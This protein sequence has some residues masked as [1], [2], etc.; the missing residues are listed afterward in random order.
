MRVLVAGCGYVGTE[1]GL[2]LAADGHE[3]WGLRRTPADLPSPIRPLA[4]D[5]TIPATLDRLPSR[6][7]AVV[8]A[9]SADASEPAAYRAAYVAGLEHLE[10]ALAR[11]PR[12]AAHPPCLVFIS[13]TAVYG[14][15]AGG[16]VDEATAPDPA[17][18]RGEILLEAER[19]ARERDGKTV[20][21][22]PSG[23]YGPGRDRLLR[24]AAQGRLEGGDRWTNRIHRDDLAEAIRHALG[25]A[26]PSPLYLASD[27]E[28]ARLGEVLE[29]LAAAIGVPWESA[30][31][32]P[33]V[34][35]KRCLPRRLLDE[36]FAFEFPT[37]REGYRSVIGST[38]RLR[39][40][41]Q[42]ISDRPSGFHLDRDDSGRVVS[43]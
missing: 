2:R 19:V 7:D 28:P 25:R 33:E 30:T 41:A 22:R 34:P 27:R 12:T 9:V 37:W 21:V 8:Y 5:L 16:A 31:D 10:A 35:G 39:P 3:V 24:R 14:E 20:I 38:S 23:I 29:W 26:S 13:S 36:G 6:L 32:G 1:L 11:D 43:R 4:A 18:F 15:D 42:H 40:D 17:N